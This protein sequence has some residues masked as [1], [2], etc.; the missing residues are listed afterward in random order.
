MVAYEQGDYARAGDYMRRAWPSAG[1]M[2]DTWGIATSLSYLGSLAKQHGDYVR[3]TV[4]HEESLA[5]SRELGVQVG[6][7]NSLNNLGM[8]AYE[9]GDYARARALY[10][11]S[12]ALRREIGH[13][14]EIVGLSQVWR[15]WHVWPVLQERH[16]KS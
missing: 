8:V 11:E 4:L 16:Q 12:L 13:T 1:K 15:G 10:E 2:N 14:W 3:A 5:L 9:R 6:I 7:A